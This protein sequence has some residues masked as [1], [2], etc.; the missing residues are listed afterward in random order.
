LLVKNNIQVSVAD[1]TITLTGEVPT[2]AAMK[3]AAQEARNMEENYTLVNG[4]KVKFVPV[5]DSVLA[6]TV[7]DRINNYVFYSIFDW[8]TAEANNG[9]VTL[10]GWGHLPWTARQIQSV[11]EKIENVQRVDNQIQFIMGSDDLR[12][13][14]ARAIYADPRFEWYAFYPMPPI[15]I[16]VDG[17][18]IILE[19]TVEGK[20][21]KSWA[22]TLAEFNTD[23]VHVVNNLKVSK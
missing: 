22:E 1:N 21:D 23:A 8:V 17:P 12:Y 9:A 19:G 20:P 13:R 16:I 15:H 7:Q 18:D 14:A 5:A 6:K 2:I 11:V 10:K 4:L 3:R